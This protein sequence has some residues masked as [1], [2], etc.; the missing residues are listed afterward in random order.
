MKG[1]KM[2]QICNIMDKI[3]TEK[4][5]SNSFVDG[6]IRWVIFLQD[7]ML[8]TLGIQD[9]ISYSLDE[10]KK[11]CDPRATLLW[12]Q[13]IDGMSAFSPLPVLMRFAQHEKENKLRVCGLCET[14][15]KNEG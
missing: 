14:E 9:S 2:S 8:T 11:V 1:V 7:S 15:K 12:S 10:S 6:I 3:W 13:P 4:H 5:E